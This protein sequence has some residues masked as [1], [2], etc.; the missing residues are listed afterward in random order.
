MNISAQTFP[1]ME[2]KTAPVD[3]DSSALLA[4]ELSV[5][6]P[7]AKVLVSRGYG[8]PDTAQDF[9]N[10][11]L[12]NLGDPFSLPGMELAISRT[13]VAIEQGTSILVYGD[14]DV[15]GVCSTALVFSVL[16]ELGAR[17]SPFLPH[18][19]DDGYGLGTDTLRRC[20][21]T[22]H[23]GLIITVDCGTGSCEAVKMAQDEGVDVIV[24]DHHEAEGEPAEAFALV[25]PK[26]GDDELSRTLAGAGVAFKFC[27]ALVKQGMQ[28]NREEAN[29]IDLRAFMDL[30]AIAT[31]ADVVPLVG[32]NRI[33]VRHGLARLNQAPRPGISALLEI[34]G[35]EHNVEAT[36]IG[37]VI[38]P[39]LNAAGRLGGANAALELLLSDDHGESRQ[40]ANELD[41]ANRERR[42]IE[43]RIFK[44]AA[45]EIDE[46]FST[47]RI[48]GIVVGREGW[49]VGTIGIVAAR[50]C[51]RFYR[52]SIVIGFN[53][54]GKGRGS[55]RSIDRVDIL[56]VLRDCNDLLI[57][58]GGHKMA[59]GLELELRHYDEFR[60]RFNAVCANRLEGGP[61]VPVQHVDAW[62]RMGE[63]DQMLVDAQELLSPL[64]PGNPTPVWGVRNVRLAAPPK[65]VGRGNQHLKMTVAKGGSQLDA[66]GFNL[67]P[68]EPPAGEM[69][70]V[71]Q[72][73]E[74]TFRGRT[75]VQMNVKD[76]RPSSDSGYVLDSN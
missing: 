67:G 13:W 11:R 62:I 26:F 30:V 73:N 36:H 45:P 20:L 58:Y 75:M 27:H 22:Y 12:S 72:L 5:P 33:L 34:A 60:E 64:G 69:D 76:L 19:I 6:L 10:P 15:D 18:R 74:N 55:C 41:A 66:I 14:Y 52:P 46:N 59:A 39:R 53:E 1:L 21:D 47:K 49:H 42:E 23:P 28:E 68:V 43:D 63:A 3:A 7:V 57:T 37:F 35:L 56:E 65:R 29:R 38:G 40:W 70:M 25:N 61:L 17:V 2:W 8:S 50:L 31:V 24:T 9:L 54:N 4:R 16:R 48:F 44:D 51:S 71:F 32:E